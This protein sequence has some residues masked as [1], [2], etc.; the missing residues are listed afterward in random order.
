VYKAEGARIL[1]TLPKTLKTLKMNPTLFD[2]IIEALDNGQTKPEALEFYRKESPTSG[3]QIQRL[4]TRSNQLEYLQKT[5]SLSTL[6][7]GFHHSLQTYNEIISVSITKL[8]ISVYSGSGNK[9]LKLDWL[10]SCFPSLKELNVTVSKLCIVRSKTNL[11]QHPHLYRLG[12]LEL[13]V[14]MVVF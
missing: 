13:S 10:L 7:A 4:F 1:L 8:T 12:I 11:V 9:S 2:N 6:T 5:I 3:K 14:P